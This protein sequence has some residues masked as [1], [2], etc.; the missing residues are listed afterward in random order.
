MIFFLVRV[1][2]INMSCLKFSRLPRSV[3]AAG[4]KDWLADDNYFGDDLLDTMVFERARVG[5]VVCVYRS[6]SNF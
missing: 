3:T 2:P 6:V 4:F 1:F 5:L